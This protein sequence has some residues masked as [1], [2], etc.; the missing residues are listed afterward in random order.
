MIEVAQGAMETIRNE[1]AELEEKIEEGQAFMTTSCCPSWVELANKHNPRDEAF[2]FEHRI[3]DVITPRG[4]PRR[5]TPTRKWS[6]S[7]RA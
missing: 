6:S 3:A 4:S 7:A 1:G 5:N 2:N